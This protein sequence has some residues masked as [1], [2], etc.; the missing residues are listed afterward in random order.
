[1]LSLLLFAASRISVG[2][3]LDFY[4]RKRGLRGAKIV[5][6][7]VILNGAVEVMLGCSG[8]A[9]AGLL[10]LNKAGISIPNSTD[11]KLSTSFQSS[12]CQLPKYPRLV[13][14]IG[15]R[16]FGNEMRGSEPD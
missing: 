14:C 2:T 1:M 5:S 16:W 6:K 7:M 4:I 10:L 8:R 15:V 9:R 3:R 13:Y 11:L 12:P